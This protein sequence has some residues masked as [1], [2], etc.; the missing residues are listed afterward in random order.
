MWVTS[1]LLTGMILQVIYLFDK[2]HITL[3]EIH[4]SPETLGVED[5]FPFGMAYVLVSGG[6][7]SFRECRNT[8]WIQLLIRQTHKSYIYIYIY[9]IYHNLV[10]KVW[11]NSMYP[12]GNQ[13]IPPL[14]NRK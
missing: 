5:E 1:Y 6:Y 8:V 7:V 10:S 9:I 12:P 14:Q 11:F 4:I 3:P 13:H 2:W